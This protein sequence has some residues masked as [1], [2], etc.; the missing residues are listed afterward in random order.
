MH[1]QVP[2]HYDHH[3]VHVIHPPEAHDEWQEDDEYQLSHGRTFDSLMD[4]YSK[5]SDSINDRANQYENYEKYLKKRSNK[6]QKLFNNMAIGWRGR[7][8]F[9]KIASEYLDSIKKQRVPE[10]DD[11]HDQYSPYDDE[12]AKRKWKWSRWLFNWLKYNRFLCQNIIKCN[13]CEYLFEF[14]NLLKIKHQV[15]SSVS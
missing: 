2:V 13:C 5:Y 1:H 15:L 4:D 6:K 14:R 3:D 7:N 8:D 12:E 11:Y 10:S 9:D